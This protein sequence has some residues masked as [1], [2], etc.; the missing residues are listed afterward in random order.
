MLTLLTHTPAHSTYTVHT[1]LL[2]LLSDGLG[3]LVPLE[4]HH[5]L[6][7]K[8][9][10]LLLQRLGRQILSFCSL[11]QADTAAFYVRGMATFRQCSTFTQLTQLS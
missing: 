7:V 2:V 1:H 10:R 6:G 3:L 8:A 4:P 5:V 9:P 11:Q